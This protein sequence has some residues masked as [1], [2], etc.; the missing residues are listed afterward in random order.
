MIRAAK[1][2]AKGEG[3][4]PPAL[5]LAFRC[6]RWGVLPVEGGILDQPEWLMNQLDTS[7]SVYDAWKM[8]SS[9]NKKDR[10]TDWIRK[11]PQMWK[12]IKD[13]QKIPEE[14]DGD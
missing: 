6:E 5:R 10:L 4:P 8:Y 14:N 9:R 11:Y 2:C 12:I 7:K 13:T 3:T 1:Q